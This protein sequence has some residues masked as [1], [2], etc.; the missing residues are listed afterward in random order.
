MV[1]LKP[2][3]MVVDDDPSFLPAVVRLI[4]TG[5]YDVQG[6]ENIDGLRARLPLPE[7]C[8]VLLDVVLRGES[9]LDIPGMLRA[10]GEPAAVVFMSATEDRDKIETASSLGIVPCLKKP[11][12]ATTLF[13]ALEI[14]L[15]SLRQVSQPT[16]NEPG[17]ME[18]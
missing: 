16:I 13:E 17:E 18:Q 5:G 3:V 8:C 6:F 1:R 2:A 11:L 14:A 12:E 15:L 4:R 10:R 7:N 9:G